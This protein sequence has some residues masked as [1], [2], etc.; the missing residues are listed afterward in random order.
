MALTFLA[1]IIGASHSTLF[2]WGHSDYRPD[3]SIDL[4]GPAHLEELGTDLGSSMEQVPP[5]V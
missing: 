3:P 2:F 5:Q 4:Q 1:A